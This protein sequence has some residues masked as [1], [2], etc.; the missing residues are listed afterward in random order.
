MFLDTK[1]VE[2][3]FKIVYNPVYMYMGSRVAYNTS[4][5]ALH[6][7]WTKFRKLDVSSLSGIKKDI[8]LPVPFN[9]VGLVHRTRKYRKAEMWG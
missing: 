1:T 9:R 4:A 7:S 2:R 6:H 8:F 5:I 3:S